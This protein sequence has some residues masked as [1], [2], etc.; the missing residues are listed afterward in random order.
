MPWVRPRPGLLPLAPHEFKWLQ[1]QPEIG[2]VWNSTLAEDTSQLKVRQAAGALKQSIQRDPAQQLG[3]RLAVYGSNV[4][5]IVGQD[6]ALC[7][8]AALWQG[9]ALLL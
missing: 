7:C 4:L 8:M 6:P 5:I 9:A 2:L 1:A 3:Q